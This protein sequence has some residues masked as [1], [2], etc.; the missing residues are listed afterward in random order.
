MGRHIVATGMPIPLPDAIASQV[1]EN[2]IRRVIIG[3]APHGNCQTVIK[4]PHQQHDTCARD[5]S[6]VFQDVIM[7]DTS[8]SD[9]RAPDNRGGAASEVVVEP[10]GR[11][12]V[13]GVFENGHCI[14]YKLDEDPWVGRWLRDGTMNGYSYSYF[15]HSVAKLRE[16]GLRN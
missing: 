1:S 10:S 4:Q 7:C 15:Y 16:I 13:N 12:L 8:Y 2:G 6:M 11:M 5:P 3:H 14:K 9:A